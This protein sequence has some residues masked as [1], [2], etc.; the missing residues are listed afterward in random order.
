MLETWEDL[1]S[2]IEVLLIRNHLPRKRSY[3]NEKADKLVLDEISSMI[4]MSK[5]AAEIFKLAFKVSSDLF[6]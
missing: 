2:L 3:Q 5:K 6:E 4:K 1:R